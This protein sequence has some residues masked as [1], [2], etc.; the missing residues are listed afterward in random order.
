LFSFSDSV[1]KEN[2]TFKWTTL[3]GEGHCYWAI[4]DFKE[5]GDGKID[6]DNVGCT[7]YFCKD[8]AR[9]GHEQ[10][11][12]GNV[13]LM[14]QIVETIPEFKIITAHTAELG[15]EMALDH[16]PDFILMDINLP[17]MNGIQALKHLKE[18]QRTES[19]PV[20]AITASVM[21]NNIEN[22]EKAE[23]DG[24]LAKPINVRET[25]D[26]FDRML[27]NDVR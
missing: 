21:S 25:I 17:G 23:F 5:G 3:W 14:E 1:N 10:V 9:D 11:H 2:S 27:K 8:L 13:G 15:L 22:I 24:F 26:L 20:I 19:I 6:L 16:L 18:K 4:N 12:M 7:C